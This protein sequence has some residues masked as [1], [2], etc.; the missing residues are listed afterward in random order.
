M[1]RQRQ[2]N[3][4]LAHS[5]ISLADRS[6]ASGHGASRLSALGMAAYPDLSWLLLALLDR[7]DFGSSSW[8]QGFKDRSTPIVCLAAG[9][10]P[11]VGEM[12]NRVGSPGQVARRIRG[13]AG[14]QR[15]GS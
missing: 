6:N 5:R 3:K 7:S 11:V 4:A 12:P 13:L 9:R 14:I 2:T 10:G 15:A 1:Q 8:R